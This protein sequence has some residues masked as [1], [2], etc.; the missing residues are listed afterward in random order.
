MAKKLTEK[1]VLQLLDIPDF[2]HMSK[3]KI[4]TFASAIPNMDPSVA[5][6]ALKQFPDF[7]KTSVSLMTDAKEVFAQVLGDASKSDD[8]YYRACD[9]VVENIEAALADGKITRKERSEL[10][11]KMMNVLQMMSEKNTENK[12]F[13]GKIAQL[14]AAIAIAGISAAAMVL[15]VNVN[16]NQVKK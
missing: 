10:I 11:D 13:I 4:M 16:L 15:G 6:T 9:M 3:D 2:R 1:E 7:A 8:A 12:Q 5:L 14:T